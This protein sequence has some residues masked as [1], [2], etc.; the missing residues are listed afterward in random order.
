MNQNLTAAQLAAQFDHAATDV[1][2]AVGKVVEAAAYRIRGKAFDAVSGDGGDAPGVGDDGEEQ[3]NND[4]Y[5]FAARHI[6]AVH[7]GGLEM[8]IGYDNAIEPLAASIEYG[9]AAAGPGGHLAKEL[10]TEAPR[11]AKVIPLAAL[12]RLR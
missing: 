8:V 10:K 7:D 3:D 12:K 1:T 9:G 11:F 6:E 5:A 2:D 4:P